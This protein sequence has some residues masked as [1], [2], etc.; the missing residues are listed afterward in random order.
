MPKAK[1][2]FESFDLAKFFLVWLSESGEQQ[3]FEW[4]EEHHNTSATI[5]YTLHKLKATVTTFP[6]N[7]ETIE[8]VKESE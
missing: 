6:T 8:Q 7:E 2:K 5:D 3:F 4:L 1:I